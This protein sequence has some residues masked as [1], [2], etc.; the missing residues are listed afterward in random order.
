[1]EEENMDYDGTY[2]VLNLRVNITPKAKVIATESRGK[3]GG[4]ITQYNLSTLF[5]NQSGGFIGY[6]RLE[7]KKLI[8]NKDNSFIIA[9]TLSK[10]CDSVVAIVGGG[11]RM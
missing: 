10:R 6:R 2:N 4:F 1:M 3:R 8:K 5:L 9:V 7:L 11:Y